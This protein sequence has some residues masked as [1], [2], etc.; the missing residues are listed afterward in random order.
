M[1]IHSLQDRIEI[2]TSIIELYATGEFTMKSCAEAHAITEGTFYAWHEELQVLKETYKEAKKKVGAINRT[3]LKLAAASSLMKL[4]AGHEV[5]ETTQE[6]EMDADGKVLSKKLKRHKK[7]YAP[8][9]AAVFFAL[10][11][12]D[13]D[14]FG[15]EPLPEE[16]KSEQ[17]FLVNGKEVKF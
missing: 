3:K 2:G 14:T 16:Q 6:I 9:A 1:I 8:H 15:K 5:E 4:V 17:I 11:S 13:A 12:L 7:V 10:R